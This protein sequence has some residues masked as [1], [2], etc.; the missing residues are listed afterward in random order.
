VDQTAGGLSSIQNKGGLSQVG[1]LSPY[2][3]IERDIEKFDLD[4]DPKK[5]YAALLQMV[6][7]PNYRMMRANNTLMLID[8]HGDGTGDGILF[9]ADKPQTFVKTLIH[10][11]KALKVGGF[12]KMTFTSSGIAIE[13]LMKKANLNYDIKPGKLKVGSKIIDG[14]YITVYE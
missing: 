10:F 13:P 4:L 12:H 2:Q 6:E 9:T 8:N 5:T 3:I 11:N 14:N 1:R 7:K